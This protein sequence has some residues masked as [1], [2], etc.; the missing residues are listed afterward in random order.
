MRHRAERGLT[1]V[2]VLVALSI[3]AVIAVLT[4]RGIDGMARAPDDV[5][6]VAGDEEDRA[7]APQPLL[8]PPDLGDDLGDL[9]AAALAGELAAYAV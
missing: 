2:E 8:Q 1:L 3:M 9:D 4:W 5:Q 6:G 7:E